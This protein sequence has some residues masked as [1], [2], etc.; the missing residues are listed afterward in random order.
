MQRSYCGLIDLKSVEQ[1][2][3]IKGWV[4]TRRDHGGV[5]FL[6]V[7]D[8]EGICQADICLLYTSQS[9]RDS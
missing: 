9:P 8:L 5:I 6:D 2:L 1:N 3:V 7:R 4:N